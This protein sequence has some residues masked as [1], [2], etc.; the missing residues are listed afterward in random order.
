MAS[1]TVRNN[2][3]GTL[4]VSGI[5]AIPVGQTKKVELYQPLNE[6]HK[7]EIDALA[8]KGQITVV[9]DGGSLSVGS[10][11]I[12]AGASATPPA[13]GKPG[14]LYVQTGGTPA[15]HLRGASAWA[16]V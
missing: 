16:T 2:A 5:G 3:R 12:T 1:I 9:N 13:D 8:K 11:K 10:V 14:D 15:L 6:R 7:A 4:F